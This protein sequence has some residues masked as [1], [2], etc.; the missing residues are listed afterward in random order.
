MSI[1]GSPM[2]GGIAMFVGGGGRATMLDESLH[3]SKM[4]T[5]GS[6]VDGGTSLVVLEGRVSSSLEKNLGT[7][8][9]TISNLT[10]NRNNH[11]LYTFTSL[12]Y[13]RMVF[14]CMS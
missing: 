6:K 10:S 3:Q 7:L 5:Q 4:A 9:K 13:R 2:N 1:V 14:N 8:L 11:Q 12:Q